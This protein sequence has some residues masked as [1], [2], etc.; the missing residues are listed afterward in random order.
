MVE[1]DFWGWQHVAASSVK[2][3]QA[4]FTPR[5][6]CDIVGRIMRIQ[7]LVTALALAVS[8]RALSQTPATYGVGFRF[9]RELD[10]SRTVGPARD[11]EGRAQSPEVA[12][13]MLIGVWYPTTV[14]RTAPRMSVGDYHL[15]SNQGDDTRPFTDAD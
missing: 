3:L 8:P 14:A 2:L 4:V 11:F 10:H 7:L 5:K 1:I 15:L 6:R 13:P 12:V 9:M